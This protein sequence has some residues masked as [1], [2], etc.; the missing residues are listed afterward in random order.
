MLD[1]KTFG[2][3]FTKKDLWLKPQIKKFIEDS[4]CKIVYFILG[5]FVFLC[6]TNKKQTGDLA[7]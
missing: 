2:Q 3:Y 1:K 6:I 4:K 5:T 7:H